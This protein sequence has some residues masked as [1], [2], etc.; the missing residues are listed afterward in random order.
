MRIYSPFPL[1]LVGVCL[2][3]S[4]ACSDSTNVKF[5]TDQSDASASDVDDSITD[6]VDDG[7][8]NDATVECENDQDATNEVVWLCINGMA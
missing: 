2:L 8:D 5:G 7:S 4:G 6:S 3:I 1:L